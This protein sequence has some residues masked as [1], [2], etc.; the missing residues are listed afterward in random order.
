M[1]L[2]QGLWSLLYN[3]LQRRIK[4]AHSKSVPA[5]WNNWPDLYG[6]ETFFQY[7]HRNM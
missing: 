3:D 2:K 5:S 4:S 1:D 6:H 7:E